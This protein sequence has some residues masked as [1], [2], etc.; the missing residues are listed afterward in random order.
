MIHPRWFLVFG[1]I[2]LWSLPAGGQFSRGGDVELA[3]GAGVAFPPI[4]KGSSV[5]TS[6]G[7][8]IHLNE[9]VSVHVGLL[10]T[11]GNVDSGV[12]NVEGIA[13]RD[14]FDLSRRVA[15]GRIAVNW[16]PKSYPFALYATGGGGVAHLRQEGSTERNSANEID[17]V[18]FQATWISP[19]AIVGG[20]AKL[21][22]K[23]ESLWGIS[24]DCFHMFGISDSPAKLFSSG[25][26]AFTS[27]QV[28]MFF[29][30]RHYTVKP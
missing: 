21:T 29:V 7:G 8:A 6:I 26:Q 5:L 13:L 27:V 16:Q 25:A 1:C 24:V 23:P 17:S 30:F 4:G 20:G 28:S 10:D 2:A 22:R 19:A 12:R 11:E 15:F 18:P 9:L 3:I 14:R